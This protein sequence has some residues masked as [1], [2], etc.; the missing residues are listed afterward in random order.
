MAVVMVTSFRPGDV[1]GLDLSRLYP[2]S[3]VSSYQH[4]WTA[5]QSVFYHCLVSSQMGW[6][7][8]GM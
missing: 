5:A 3:D 7:A 4:I 1:P 8:V 2:H 6:S